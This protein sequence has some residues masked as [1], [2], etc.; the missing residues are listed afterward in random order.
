MNLKS[1]SDNIYSQSGEDGIIKYLLSLISESHPL[2]KWCVEFGAW[3][4][5][6]LSNTFNLVENYSYKGVYIEGSK[7]HFINLKK[8]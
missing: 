1:Y 7:K 5:K 2:S 3:D 6:F 4:G 8:I